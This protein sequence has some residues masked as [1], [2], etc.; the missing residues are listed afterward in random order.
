LILSDD[1]IALVPTAPEQKMKVE[2]NIRGGVNR[3][4]G[5]KSKPSK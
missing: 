3:S 5:S 1:G 4:G 2:K